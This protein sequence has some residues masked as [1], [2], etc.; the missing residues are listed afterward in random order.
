M[1]MGEGAE[2]GPGTV[3][4]GRYRLLELVGSGGMGSVWRA[5]DELLGREVAMKEVRLDRQPGGDPELA[6]VRT[7]REARRRPTWWR[8]SSRLP[9]AVGAPATLGSMCGRAQGN[10]PNPCRVVGHRR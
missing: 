10:Q 2:G 4:A 6:R 1:S 5:T 8:R 9:D 7:L 3:V